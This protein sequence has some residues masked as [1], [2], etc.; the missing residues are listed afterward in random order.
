MLEDVA[1]V[2]RPPIME[3]RK[4]SMTIAKK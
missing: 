4:M 3:G 1:K 2:E